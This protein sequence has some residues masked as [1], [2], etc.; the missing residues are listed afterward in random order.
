MAASIEKRG[1]LHSTCCLL[2]HFGFRASVVF[3]ILSCFPAPEGL[4]DIPFGLDAPML[5]FWHWLIPWVGL[6]FLHLP[7]QITESG[8]GDTLYSY[9]KLL[10]VVVSSV[11]AA[12]AW[13]FLD[14]RRMGAEKV[15]TDPL[16]REGLRVYLRYVLAVA[17]LGYG[18]VK[19]F[20]TQFWAPSVSRLLQPLGDSS[21]MGLLWTF[22]GSSV[23]YTRFAGM[24]ELLG[25]L[26]LFFRRT[27]TLGA[28]VLT[29]VLTQVVA[30]NFCYDVPVKL[31][32]SLL[33]F[34]A[35]YL[36][37]PDASR[38]IE[39]F[40]FHRPTTLLTRRIEFPRPWL[41]T[42]YISLKVL[43]VGGLILYHARTACTDWQTRLKVKT[44]PLS[45]TYAV[46]ESQ[47]NQLSSAQQ[48]VGYSPFRHL[49]FWNSQRL[50]IISIDGKSQLYALHDDPATSTLALFSIDIH[51]T[52]QKPM[53]A[54]SL[55]Y[56]FP[57]QRTLL[58][59]GTIRMESITLRL[60][61]VERSDFLLINHGFHWVQEAPFNE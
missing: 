56:S 18:F 8:S 11:V 25:G 26:L 17:M 5:A 39:F 34:M 52:E 24:G 45:A 48:L 4:L 16:L 41:R 33:L 46:E 44:G 59:K 15:P 12:T 42:A 61:K 37:L 31:G 19:V 1:W 51:A 57:N 55:E 53:P 20:P 29:V 58:L 38:L 28:L 47:S 3:W 49:I 2:K 6:R 7:V 23:A 10:V 32:S 50:R 22:M 60:R 36:L 14:R 40:W 30:L 27:T 21:P 43:L 13:V 35:L 9:V 54:G